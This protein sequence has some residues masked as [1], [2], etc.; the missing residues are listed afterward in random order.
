MKNF[1]IRQTILA[2]LAFTFSNWKKLLEVSIFPLLA[3]L[4]F[5]TILPELMTILQAQFFGVGEVKAY[6]RLYELYLLM[7]D[8]AYMAL[9]INIYRLVVSGGQSVARLGVVM[10]NLR[11][12]RFFLLFIFLSIATQFPIF[13]SPFLIPIIYFLLIPT[14]LNLVGLANDASYKRIKLNIS[15]Q[16]SV[17]L[18]KLGVPIILVGLTIIIGVNEMIFWGIM[19]L[20]MYWM[21]I[22]FA[23]CY[24]VIMANSSTQSH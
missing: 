5:I 8:Y 4:P 6:P 7:F 9:I 15:V 2:T 16:F 17:F 13:I 10:P 24:R 23:L 11:L 14:S 18:I 21:A 3:A 20:I 12:G 1:P 22:S 19:V